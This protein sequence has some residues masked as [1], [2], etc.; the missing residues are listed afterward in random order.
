MLFCAVDKCKRREKPLCTVH[1]IITANVLLSFFNQPAGNYYLANYEASS[2]SGLNAAFN[3]LFQRKIN[4]MKK[5]LFFFLFISFTAAALSQKTV[6]GKVYNSLTK[7]P[8]AGA[9]IRVQGLNEALLSDVNGAF[10]F[11]AP[12]TTIVVSA[13]GYQPMEVSLSASENINIALQ[14][15]EKPLDELIVTASRSLQRRGDAPVSITKIT[16]KVIAETKPRDILEL[17]NKVP[18]VVMTNLNN[19]QH[20]MS[21]R[22]PMG[23]TSAYHL[24][25]EDG[26][27]IRTMGVFNHNALIEI[28]IPA[29]QSIEV[30]KGPASSIYGPEAIGGSI[31]FINLKPTA[32]ATIRAGVQVDNYGYRRYNLASTGMLSKKIGYAINGNYTQ[33]RNGWLANTDFDKWA[34]TVRLDYKIS[35]KTLLWSSYTGIDYETQASGSVDS[36]GFYSKTYPSATGFT[37]RKVYTNRLRTTIEHQWNDRNA[38]TLTFYYRNNAVLQSANHTIRWTPR[39]DSASTESNDARFRSY[40]FVAQHGISLPLLS[41]KVLAGVSG[42]VSPHRFFSNPLILNAILRPDGMS[43]ERYTIRRNPSDVFITNYDSEIRNLGAWLQTEVAPFKNLRAVVGL[44][45]DRFSYQYDR[46]PTMTQPMTASGSRSYE[47]LVPRIG[48]TYN[49]GKNAAVFANYS[50]GFVQ[51]NLSTLF[52]PANPQGLNLEPATFDNVEVGGWASLLT[53]ELFID[54][55]LYELKGRNE[56]ISIRQPDGS[57]LPTSV[58]RTLH[59]GIEYGI[60]YTPSKQLSLRVSATNA[61]H[62]F[63]EFELSKRQSDAVKNVDGKVMPQS[64]TFIANTEV[65]Y[66]P[67]WAKGFRISAEWQRMSE[68]YQ[69]QVNTVKYNDKGLLGFTGISLLNLRTGYEWKGVELFL[70]VYN[71]TDELYANTAT[72]GNNPGDRSSFNP[73]APRIFNFGLQYSFTAKK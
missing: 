41:T 54:I 3:L 29:I 70:N 34:G 43:V 4:T 63:E 30:V 68:W 21:I 16:P 33:Q 39:L 60:S 23:T 55:T 35:P 49:L 12:V 31:N 65:T 6:S 2:C 58:G 11:S 66:R 64:P 42:D 62:R 45:Y 15:S 5:F 47:K 51:A 25:L 13:T 37:Y 73:G 27:P 38:S 59:R 48:A 69:N 26:I 57:S 22:Q 56:V 46:L 36:A 1:C 44:R 72:R 50:K 14:P 52:N 8:V 61:L 10:Q 71:V 32:L 17:V 24:Y 20:S 18:G 40:G 19:E 7:E 9:T 67:A 53:N 28:N